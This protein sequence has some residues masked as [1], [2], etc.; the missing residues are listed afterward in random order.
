MTR[1]EGH[2]REVGSFA[3]A[4]PP[5]LPEHVEHPLSRIIQEATAIAVDRACARLGTRLAGG[6]LDAADR[7][8]PA[9]G[10]HQWDGNR[11]GQAADL[12]ADLCA[13]PRSV[14]VDQK[15]KGM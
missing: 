13:A 15:A 11:P 7:Y 2:L 12:F 14:V 1:S 8:F 4:G 9:P 5:R 3:A 10:V 6:A